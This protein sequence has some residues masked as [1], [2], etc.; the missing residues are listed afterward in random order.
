MELNVQPL[1]NM[2]KKIAKENGFEDVIEIIEGKVEDVQLPVQQV[3]IIIS[4]WMG[5]FFIV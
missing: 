3:D 2:Q 4:E 5:F 1:L